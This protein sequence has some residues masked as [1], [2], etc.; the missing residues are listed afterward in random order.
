MATLILSITA[1]ALI[2]SLVSSSSASTEH[3]SLVSV[4]TVLRSFA[5]SAAYQIQM[6][7]VG[8]GGGPTYTKC[9]LTT[10][11]ALLSAPTPATGAAGTA[12]TV[13]APACPL[14]LP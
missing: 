1:A 4:N 13:F 5:D 9:A 6:Q 10:T 14:P 11:Y 3:R 8:A 7:P 12:A 2:N